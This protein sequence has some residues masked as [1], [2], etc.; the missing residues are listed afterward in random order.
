MIKNFKTWY[1]IKWSYV[2]GLLLTQFGVSSCGIEEDP[3]NGGGDGG[4]LLMY[5]SPRA[6]YELSI[7]VKNE[8]GKPLANQ[9]IIIRR[10][11]EKMQPAE[12]TYYPF[13]C[14]TV[15][16]DSDGRYKGGLKTITMKH[17]LRA[18]V[19]E[20]IDTSLKPDSVNIEVKQI[21]KG[22]GAWYQGKFSGSAEIKLKKK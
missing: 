9:K 2:L 21:K 10:L 12:Y 3:F 4:G 8:A 14:D 20:P 22:D 19:K 16:T 11:N 15:I 13:S 17:N 7:S 1:R 18:V 6:D 5:G